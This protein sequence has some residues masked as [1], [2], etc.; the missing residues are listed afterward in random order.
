MKV[1]FKVIHLVR[2]S[3]RT[4]PAINSRDLS[5]INLSVGGEIHYWDL[6]EA[7]IKIMFEAGSFGLFNF[8][9][10]YLFLLSLIHINS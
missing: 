8:D 1:D 5:I 4:I 7:K 10:V 9:F 3:C 2:V 6:F